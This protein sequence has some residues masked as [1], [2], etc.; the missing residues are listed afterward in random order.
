MT[1]PD[2]LGQ[3]RDQRISWTS[4]LVAPAVL[5][6]ELEVSAPAARVVLSARQ[7]IEAILVGADD[8]LLVVVG[9]CSVHD[10]AAG[11]DYAGRLAE[12]AGSLAHELVIVMRVYFEKP[13]TTLGWKGMINDPHLD[14]SFAVKEGITTARRLVLGVLERGLP[15]GCEFLD[16]IIPQYLS[17]AVSWAAIGARTVESQVHRQLASGLSMPVGLKN[18]TDGSLKAAID[19]ARAAAASHVFTGVD[20]DGRAAIFA[21][22]GNVD[23][24]IVLRGGRGGPNFSERSVATA[25]DALGQAGLRPQV[26]LDASHANSGG[27]ERRQLENVLAL[28][29]RLGR[30]EPG[31]LG[32]M[33]ESFLVGGSQQLE[34]GGRH[35]LRYGQSITDACLSFEE[36]ASA[37]RALAGAVAARRRA[38]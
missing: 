1:T 24:H 31:V 12:L 19:A 23:T 3:L 35:G 15:V 5:R 36:T 2:L 11:L 28:A 27:D 10:E 16:P 21:T 9:P 4:P 6:A 20:D 37:L 14:G 22:T 7:A 38:A 26:M 25:M 18:S 17:D 34:L 33:I 30:G 8:R 13:R 29:E 32:C